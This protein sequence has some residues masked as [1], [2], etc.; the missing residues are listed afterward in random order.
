M[1]ELMGALWEGK[2]MQ[3]ASRDV[4]VSMRKQLQM[5]EKKEEYVQKKIE[6]NLAKA[7]ANL[8]THKAGMFIQTSLDKTNRFDSSYDCIFPICIFV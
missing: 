4:I 3:Q 8:V 6:E 5:I 2:D 1:A 7:K